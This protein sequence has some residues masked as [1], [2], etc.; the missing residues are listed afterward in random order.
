MGDRWRRCWQLGRKFDFAA[1]R[2]LG[3]DWNSTVLSVV[4][5]GLWILN[6]AD[7]QRIRNWVVAVMLPLCLQEWLA[8]SRFKPNLSV[9]EALVWRSKR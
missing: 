2:E 5:G 9:V 6:H 1:V 7:I 4:F 3:A 8:T